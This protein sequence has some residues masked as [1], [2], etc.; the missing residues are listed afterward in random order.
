MK[1]VI[2]ATWSETEFH[3]AVSEVLESLE[4]VVD[5][6]PEYERTSREGLLSRKGLFRSGFRGLMITVSSH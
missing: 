4:Y 1:D 5:R 6:H 3:Q 2:N